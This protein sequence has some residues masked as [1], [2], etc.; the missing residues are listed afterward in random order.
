VK[1]EVLNLITLPHANAVYKRV[2]WLSN[3]RYLWRTT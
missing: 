1:Q 3:N 2:W